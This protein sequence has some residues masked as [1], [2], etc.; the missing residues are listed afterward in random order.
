MWTYKFQTV[1]KFY[2]KGDIEILI[3]FSCYTQRNIL[4]NTKVNVYEYLKPINISQCK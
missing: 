3:Y 1:T 2:L 4:L